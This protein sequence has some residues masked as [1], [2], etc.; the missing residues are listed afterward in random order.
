M[1]AKD[2]VLEGLARIRDTLH[3]SL[4]GLT[5]AEVHRQPRAD[6]N[7]I[8][9]LAWHLTRVQDV[10]V[11]GL[12]GTE[13]VWINQGWHAT[14]HMQSDPNND[15]F[16][17]TPEQVADFRA[18]S[19][20]TLLDYHDSVAEHARAYVAGLTAEDFDR[21][22]DEPQWQPLPTVGVRLVSV[23]SDNLQHAGQA[24]YLRGL[25]QG[26]GWLPY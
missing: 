7:S 5:L 22:L 17:Y 19:V 13:Q 16:G 3:R 10:S 11:S 18:P 1:Q 8:A 23:L 2:L 14:F 26:K 12:A 24:A 21:T 15:G 20:Q 6:A 9:W 25:F 4:D